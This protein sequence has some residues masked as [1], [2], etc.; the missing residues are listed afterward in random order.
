MPL[1]LLSNLAFCFRSCTPK[2]HTFFPVINALASKSYP[3][4]LHLV[5]LLHLFRAAATS[6]WDAISNV[7]VILVADLGACSSS[8]GK[9]CWYTRYTREVQSHIFLCSCQLIHFCLFCSAGASEVLCL[10]A[11]KESWHLWLKAESEV[12]RIPGCRVRWLAQRFCS[13]PVVA[14]QREGGQSCTSCGLLAG[15]KYWIVLVWG[16]FFFLSFSFGHHC[17]PGK[18]MLLRRKHSAH[19]QATTAA[20]WLIKYGKEEGRGKMGTGVS[21]G[22]HQARSGFVPD[23]WTVERLHL[24]FNGK[25]VQV[26]RILPY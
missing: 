6:L 5:T 10:I 18:F 2:L 17:Q 16:M 21:Y 23:T 9:A 25:S 14:Q 24:L 26:K 8:P 15:E 11:G 19:L 4:S 12:P 22:K 1:A 20:M 7:W 13:F 3:D